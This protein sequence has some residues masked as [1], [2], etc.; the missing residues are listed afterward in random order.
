L[1]LQVG[2][3]LKLKKKSLK[4]ENLIGWE[5]RFTPAQVGKAFKLKRNHS[6]AKA[7]LKVERLSS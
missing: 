4:S 6:T 7:S 1:K 2:K 5:G 3:P